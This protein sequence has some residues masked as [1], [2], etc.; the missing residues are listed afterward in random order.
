MSKSEVEALPTLPHNSGQLIILSEATLKGAH[1]TLTALI[2]RMCATAE[3]LGMKSMEHDAK[4]AESRQAHEFAMQK[5]QYD[6]EARMELIKVG[7][8]ELVGGEG[9][10][11]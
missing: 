7:G 2:E 10:G 4:R 8:E 11:H 3:T 1:E 5:A 6:H 9:S